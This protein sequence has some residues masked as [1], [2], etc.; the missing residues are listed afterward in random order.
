MVTLE[1]DKYMK[2]RKSYLYFSC[3]IL[4]MANIISFA[5][6]KEMPLKSLFLEAAIRFITWPA[7][8]INTPEH[9]RSKKFIIGYFK[10]SAFTPHLKQVFSRKVIKNRDVTLK[11][12]DSLSNISTCDLVFIPESEKNNLLKILKFSEGKPV[13][14][15]SDCPDFCKQGL[16]LCL[17][18]EGQK[19]NCL[20]NEE[21]A[22]KS[23]L[24][25]SYHLLQKSK[26]VK[27]QVLK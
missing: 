22:L 10:E 3:L 17:T 13:L 20:I 2:I 6:V 1:K 19:I 12:I 23:N 16:I 18:I 15:V 24:K 27:T 7:D 9:T 5:Q 4:L 25:V 8:T 26:I 21:E 11:A 14:T